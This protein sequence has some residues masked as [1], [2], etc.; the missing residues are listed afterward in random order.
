MGAAALGRGGGL[1]ALEAITSSPHF[2]AGGAEGP[3]L[4]LVP[5]SPGPGVLGKGPPGRTR[6]L[7]WKAEFE[8]RS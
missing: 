4:L 3:F 6:S 5:G 7:L 2:S 8:G 1:G